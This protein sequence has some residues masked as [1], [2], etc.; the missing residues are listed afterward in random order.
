M[1]RGRSRI[2]STVSRLVA[3]EGSRAVQ[4]LL[5]VC[6]ARREV[7]SAFVGRASGGSGRR[8]HGG[9]DSAEERVTR[10]RGWTLVNRVF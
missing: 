5:V 3:T 7:E 9:L 1:L 4:R 8:C 6:P 2:V 10:R